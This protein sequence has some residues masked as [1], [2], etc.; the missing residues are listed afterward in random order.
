MFPITTIT[1]EGVKKHRNYIMKGTLHRIQQETPN[2]DL[3]F[4]EEVYS[5]VLIF[6]K[7]FCLRIYEKLLVSWLR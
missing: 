3:D 4:T 5:K 6:A 7:D 2:Y 1:T